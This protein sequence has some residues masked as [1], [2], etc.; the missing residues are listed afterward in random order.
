MRTRE[1]TASSIERMFAVVGSESGVL[2]HEYSLSCNEMIDPCGHIRDGYI[3]T[4][5]ETL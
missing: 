5:Q 2:M 4:R 3:V 1:G